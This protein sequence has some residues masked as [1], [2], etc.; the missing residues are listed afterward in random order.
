LSHSHICVRHDV[1]HQ[2]GID[3]LV[4]EFV[5]GDTLAKRLEKRPLPVDQVLKLGAQNADA[6]DKALRAGIVRRDLIY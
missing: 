3:Y 4:M 1:G 6:L 5:E 2:D